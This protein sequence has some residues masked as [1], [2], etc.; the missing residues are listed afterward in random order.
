MAVRGFAQK[1]RLAGS[2]AP[3]LCED[4]CNS[5]RIL[6]SGQRIESAR[7]CKYLGAIEPSVQEPFLRNLDGR[8]IPFFIHPP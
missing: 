8:G 1:I 5:I 4:I 6:S 3:R 2:Q 7:F